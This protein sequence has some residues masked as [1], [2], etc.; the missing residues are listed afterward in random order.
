MVLLNAADDVLKELVQL[1]L[2]HIKL[3]KY[4]HETVHAMQGMI[5][6]LS[7]KADAQHAEN[8]NVLNEIKEVIKQ[9]TDEIRS[10][11]Q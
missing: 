8:T 5:S 1:K 4:N 2:E 7:L 6:Q 10:Q 3:T 9:L 11:K